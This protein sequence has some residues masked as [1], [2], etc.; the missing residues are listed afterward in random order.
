MMGGGRRVSTTIRDLVALAEP[1]WSPSSSQSGIPEGSP[2][3]A[4][5]EDDVPRRRPSWR[6]ETAVKKKQRAG[7][8]VHPETSLGLLAAVVDPASAR[9][10]RVAEPVRAVASV[11]GVIAAAGVATTQLT[12]CNGK[13]DA[14]TACTTRL[15]VTFRVDDEPLLRLD[16]CELCHRRLDDRAI[17]LYMDKGFCMPE[18]RYE[19]FRE[20]LYEKRK[21]KRAAE[22]RASRRAW[23]QHGSKASLD[24]ETMADR[25]G[26]KRIFFVS[27]DSGPFG[28]S[29]ETAAS[30]SS[31]M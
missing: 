20:E 22:T 30:V 13:R 27:D 21:L 19:Y 24:T 1:G 7:G 17:Y 31:S 14:T 16:S 9:L 5:N 23:R 8:G 29:P 6:P 28:H 2:F 26:F 11:A 3:A 4:G 15:L 25:S 18:C 12:T 10:R